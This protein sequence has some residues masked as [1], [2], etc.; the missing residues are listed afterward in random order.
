MTL[1][2]ILVVDDESIIRETLADA[3]EEEGWAVTHAESGDEALQIIH[4][5]EPFTALI[6]DIRMPGSA[7]G[8]AIARAARERTSDIAVVYMTGFSSVRAP[9]DGSLFFRKPFKVGHLLTALDELT[10][11][12]N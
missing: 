10:T 7:D 3:L 5:S 9:V 4:A 1:R 8:W 11:P 2:R 12:T 6:T